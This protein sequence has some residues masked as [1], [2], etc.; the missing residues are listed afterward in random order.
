MSS[1]ASVKF[2]ESPTG[3]SHYEHQRS[4]SG[5]GSFSDT[6]SRASEVEHS[7]LTPNYEDQGI[8]TISRALE[9]SQQDAKQW[10]GM[11]HELQE[12]LKK[13]RTELETTKAHL[14]GRDT[15]KEEFEHAIERLKQKNE[16][17]KQKNETLQ[18]KNETLTDTN[19][20]L[21]EQIAQLEDKVKELKKTN[22]KS[23]GNSTSSTSSATAVES[24]DEKTEKKKRSASKRRPEK[25][26]ERGREKESKERERERRKE[27]ERIQE[28][29][30]QEERLRNRFNGRAG[31]ESDALSSN[32]SGRPHRGPRETYIEPLGHSAPR[33]Q[34]PA[35]PAPARQY[36]TYH[37]SHREPFAS[38]APRAHH[39][40]VYVADDFNTYGAV[41]DEDAYR[42]P[43]ST[44]HQ[45]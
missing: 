11:V 17:L 1:R 7:Y 20:E 36:P 9:A 38:T 14:R 18:D 19:N 41:E 32:S 28:E 30:A 27:K 22:R 12:S 13:L 23:S 3:G 45:R 10:K 21:V 31:E 4:D 44:R 6:D 24:A 29:R 42:V 16:I 43:R 33:P 26:K 5:V 40:T 2:R 15:E 34:A 8:Y 35:P 39:P 37:Q 25:E